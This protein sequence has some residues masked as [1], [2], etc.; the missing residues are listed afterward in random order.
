MAKPFLA[1]GPVP[2]T[3]INSPG[4]LDALVA[5]AQPGADHGMVYRA[6]TAPD[7]ATYP[8][9]AN[10]IWI[11][12][13]GPSVIKR[14]YN[15][16]LFTW[17]AEL[18]AAGS[19]TGDMLAD[20]TITLDKIFPTPGLGGYVMRLNAGSTAVVWD[21]PANLYT[22]N[23]FAIAN[24]T[25][26]TAGTFVLSSTGS[27]NSWATIPSLLATGDIALSKLSTSGAL[28]SQTIYYNGSALAYGYPDQLLRTNQ[29]GLNVIELGAANNIP[30]INPT[31]T[32]WVFYTPAQFALLFQ[33]IIAGP[34]ISSSL[35]AVPNSDGA[36]ITPIIHGLTGTPK[37][38]WVMVNVT[39]EFNWVANDEVPDINLVHYGPGTGDFMTPFTQYANATEIGWRWNATGTFIIYIHNKNTGALETFTPGNWRLKA[40]YSV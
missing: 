15:T 18:P 28:S 40:R 21:A 3:S 27:A 17:D 26:S 16:S 12:T 19:I 25:Y 36:A 9:Y 32:A 7:I 14:T 29:V 35:I 30:A 13:S 24:L 1:P 23:T 2:G 6:A 4:E 11:D 38:D 33:G 8:I 34:I 5:S 31:G 39:P 37:V 10:F 20:E 22:N